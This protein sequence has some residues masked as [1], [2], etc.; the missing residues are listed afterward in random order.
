MPAFT[1]AVGGES[2]DLMNFSPRD[3]RPVANDLAFVIKGTLDKFLDSPL[4]Q[5]LTPHNIASLSSASGSQSWQPSGGPV[6]FT[7]AGDLRATIS[8][9]NSGS[10]FGKGDDGNDVIY[11]DGFVDPNPIE[12]FNVSPGTAFI[13]TQ[14]NMGISG[15]V[16]AKAKFDAL[17][18]TADASGN[19][20]Y[21]VTH[22]KSFTANTP[23]RQA[24]SCALAQFVLPLHANT[25]SALG[26]KDVLAYAFDG[27]L[28]V[29]FGVNYGIS[30]SLA[31]YSTSIGLPVREISKLIA[32]SSSVKPSYSVGTSFAVKFPWSRIFQCIV[33]RTDNSGANTATVHIFQQN[34]SERNVSVAAGV[35]A[36]SAGATACV[37]VDT[38]TLSNWI[39]TKLFG[40]TSPPSGFASIL[41]S[42]A[43]EI[44]KYVDDVNG[45]AQKLLTAAPGGSTGLSV[46]IDALNSKTS[47]FRYVFSV[48][49]SLFQK[50]W[51]TAMGGDFVGAFLFPT[52]VSLAA[53][54]GFD[55]FY[56]K[57]TSINLEIF[58]Y[59]LGTA[60]STYYNDVTINYAGAGRFQLSSKTGRAFSV[61]SLTAR[62][63]TDLYFA[64]TAD[65]T[66]ALEASGVAITFHAVLKANRNT[67]AILGYAD[68]LQSLGSPEAVRAGNQLRQDLT[69][70]IAIHF[71][72]STN[73][74][75]KITSTTYISGKPVAQKCQGSDE[76]NWNAY[77][78]ASRIL[79]RLDPPAN[80]LSQAPG[81]IYAEYTAWAY[82]NQTLMKGGT[83]P[84]DRRLLHVPGQVTDDVCDRIMGKNTLSDYGPSLQLFELGGQEFMN[85]CDDLRTIV[86]AESAAAIGWVTVLEDLGK[87]AKDLDPWF[88]AVVVLAIS[89]LCASSYKVVGIWGTA[90]STINVSVT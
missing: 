72:F 54:S 1:L 70:P 82:Y 62:S 28:Q 64:A 9:I 59:T 32:T 36:V 52:A 19:A 46:I 33:Q 84:P 66:A 10:I 4:S 44:Q 63:S 69:G 42:S 17:G 11:Y 40:S 43:A 58:G 16:G 51:N 86:V 75:K 37:N 30:G 41:T 49:D 27:T 24:L 50:A 18:V 81:S 38:T 45:Y 2:I 83:T 15:S 7:L 80:T 90:S 76:I 20:T 5:I 88:G 34:K 85:L 48:G 35:L 68:L 29:G 25:V 14:L 8:V 31:G 47:C 60:V 12:S 79:R 87:A 61:S 74:Y 53:D 13:V 77:T 39:K 55:E 78:Q 65:G 89:R 21:A 73:A 57:Q 22:Y 71:V 67:N 3:L 6:T 23:L 26:D 56:Q